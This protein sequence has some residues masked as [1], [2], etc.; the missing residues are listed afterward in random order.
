ML[1]SGA[2]EMFHMARSRE[3]F[4]FQLLKIGALKFGQF[5]LKLHEKRPNAP[6]SPIYI[7]LRLLRSFPAVM[8]LAVEVLMDLSSGLT[9][10]CYADVP[11]AATPVVAVLSHQTRVPMISPRRDE[12]LHGVKRRIDGAFKAGQIALLIDDLITLADSKLE[13]IATLEEN[14]L[15]VHDVLVLLDREQ[16]GVQELEKRGYRCYAGLHLREL[17]GLYLDSKKITRD[18][19]ELAIRYLANCV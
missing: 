9:F 4:A 17:L 8:D 18:Q 11:T 5:K 16:G 12:K 1:I 3:D 19:H 6:L 13:T 2:M 10:D 7:D 15:E 14:G